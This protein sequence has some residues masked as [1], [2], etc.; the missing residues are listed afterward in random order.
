MRRD[1]RAAYKRVGGAVTELD[2][3]LSAQGRNGTIPRI[4]FANG[5]DGY[6]P[7]PARWECR[8]PLFRLGWQTVRSLA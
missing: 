3:L 6:F 5:V 7:G 4:E 8:R 1:C 2:T